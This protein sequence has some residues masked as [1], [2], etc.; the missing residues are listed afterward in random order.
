MSFKKIIFFFLIV[1]LAA[2]G[3]RCGNT[4]KPS[5]EVDESLLSTNGY[6]NLHDS[7]QYVGM[8]ACKACHADIYNTFIETGMGQSFDSATVTKTKGV[9][10]KHSTFYDE[11]TKFWYQAQ[12]LNGQ[13]WFKEFRL[14]PNG[15][16]LHN[17]NE[18]AAYVVG[19]GQHTNSH[20]LNINGYLY[21]IPM[22]FYTQDKKWDLPP[23]FEDNNTRFARTIETEC[24]TC[25]NAYPKQILGS[26]HKFASIPKGIDCERCHG[27]GS[28]HVQS[29]TAGNFVDT[30]K[31]IDFTIVNP[32]KLSWDLQISLCQRCHLQG[33]TVLKPGKTFYDFKPGMQLSD[34]MSVFL[35][36]YDHDHGEFIMA[37]HADRMMLSDCFSKIP[38]KL[39]CISCHN[40]HKS[41]KTLDAN[42]FNNKCIDCH[43]TTDK[44]VCTAPAA[45]ISAKNN[46]CVSCHMPKSGTSDIPHVS[47]T[48][49]YIRIPDTEKKPAGPK[50]FIGIASINELNPAPLTKALAWLQY[51]ERFEP[52]RSHLDSALKYIKQAGASANETEGLK[53]YVHY[54][55]LM[56]DVNALLQFVEQNNKIQSLQHAWTQYRIGEA[57]TQENQLQKAKQHLGTAVSL[58]PYQLD[59]REKYAGVLIDL[60][61]LAEA[62][63]ELL[64]VVKEN[65]LIPIAY[66]N[67][68]Y[69]NMLKGNLPD[70]MIQV[71]R[72]LM[73]SPDSE[74][75]MLNKA[76]ILGMSG[77]LS[78]SKKQL[79]LLLQKYPNNAQAKAALKELNG[80]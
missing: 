46:D 41:V 45:A 3:W 74:M 13:L 65:P 64:F 6:L 7:V 78:E 23:G 67:L 22:T 30:S 38:G 43:K 60:N 57:Y 54:F 77:R 51:Y 20:L 9:F 35:P 11:Q 69:I 56:G 40:P 25:H 61:L 4:E 12:L 50:K 66:T 76:G 55:Y 58:M 8:D 63:K 75:A 16:T 80:G 70:A 42:Y 28:L 48:D 19:S 5:V 1:G 27:P 15:D 52:T 53:I 32:K 21:Q 18:Q 24:I 72:A 71:D 34:V 73:L 33:N 49:H 68:A 14:A 37:S 79:Q 62:E 39:T 36:R 10:N 59:F 29:I 31:N 26:E 47:I 2:I 17:R 44:T